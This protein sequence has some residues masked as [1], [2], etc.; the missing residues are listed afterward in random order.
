M[1]PRTVLAGLLA[2]SACASAPAPAPAA[3]AGGLRAPAARRTS[4]ADV[5]HGVRIADPYRWLEDAGSP[6]VKQWMQGQDAFARA[7]LARLPG[8]AAIAERARALTYVEAMA[9]PIPRG[10]RMFYLRRGAE[11]EKAVL[12]WREGEAGAERVLLDPNAWSA[13]GSVGLGGWM[14]SW[15]GKRVAFQKKRN[16]SDEAELRVVEVDTGAVS[17]VDVIPGAKYTEAAAW[18]PAGDGFYYT[19]VPPEGTVPVADRPGYA[20]LRFHRL[21]AA[22]ASDRMVRE[23]TGDPTSFVSATLSRDGRWLVATVAH[24][25]S[26]TDV[27]FK[28]LAQG[29][30]AGPWQ[31]LSVGRPSIVNVW[32]YGDTFYAHTND[33]AP[34]WRIVAIDP[35][36]PAPEA[37][38]TLVP[39]GA[40]TIEGFAVAGRRLVLSVMENATSRLAIHG[41]DGRH[42]ADVA[43]PAL[44]KASVPSGDEEEDLAYFSF[45]SFTFPQ[46]VRSLSLST[47]AAHLLFRP[48]APVQPERYEVEQ[49]RYPSKDGT[50]VSMFLVH[51]KGRKPDGNAPVLLYGYG[52]FQQPMLPAFSARA[53][54]WVEGGGVYAVANL[55]GGN[56]YGEAWHAQGM[57]LHKQNV[58]DDYAAAAEWLIHSGWTRPAR[59]AI[60]GGSNGGLLVGAAMTQRPELF[61]AVVCAVPLLDMVRYH[62]FGSGKTWIGEYGSADD[63]AQFS[64]LYAYSPYHHVTAGTRYPPLLLLSAD[65]DDR[66]DPMHARKFAAAVQAATTGGP[67][68]LRIEKNSGHGGADL[69]R[70]EVE[71][72]V[73]MLAFLRATLGT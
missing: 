1:I 46:E 57:L 26:S 50:Q 68:L 40:G 30:E 69:R 14:P 7:E 48:R 54:A 49:V 4:T 33:G 12:A 15:D 52:G 9:Y 34:R 43:L 44:G 17:E 13:D 45:E 47:G 22:P 25:W 6:E 73:D 64:A 56:E 11:Q 29:G 2:L 5:L 42:Q 51:A 67:V 38:R 72:T 39:E 20:E 71:K 35:A 18:T 59:L 63:P 41:L 70:A 24:G 10:G 3:R 32:P 27:W 21:G 23:R 53:Y 36:H 65:A 31:P 19:W 61:G 55:R 62:L 66:V 37:W 28:D 60:Y 8:R 16:N 58:F